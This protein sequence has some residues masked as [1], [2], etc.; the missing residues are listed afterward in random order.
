MILLPTDVKPAGEVC[1]M[2]RPRGALPR[3]GPKVLLLI[4]ARRFRLPTRDPL[5]PD[6]S[7]AILYNIHSAVEGPGDPG[8]ARFAT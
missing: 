8:R 7:P 6:K 1:C 4:R 3:L 2:P 5:S